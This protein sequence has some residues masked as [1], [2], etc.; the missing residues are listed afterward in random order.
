MNFHNRFSFLFYFLPQKGGQ[1]I[2]TNCCSSAVYEYGYGCVCLWVCLHI[3]ENFLNVT[4]IRRKLY[5]KS[6]FFIFG[7]L[8]KQINKKGK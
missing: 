4:R 6:E 3:I 2:N 7:R 5:G 1:V 8:G